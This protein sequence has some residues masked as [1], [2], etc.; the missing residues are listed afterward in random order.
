MTLEEFAVM[1]VS[2]LPTFL[3]VAELHYSRTNSV[4][5]NGLAMSAHQETIYI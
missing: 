4:A 5:D 1:L 2:M 3:Y